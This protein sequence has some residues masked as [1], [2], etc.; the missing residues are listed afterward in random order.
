MSVSS[1]EECV[2]KTQ[3][4]CSFSEGPDESMRLAG[5]QNTSKSVKSFTDKGGGDRQAFYTRVP[6]LLSY[7]SLGRGKL[8][9]AYSVAFCICKFFTSA[10]ERSRALVNT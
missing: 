4:L 7:F 10:A 5:I 6:F 9:V 1:Q 3:P 8:R 2:W